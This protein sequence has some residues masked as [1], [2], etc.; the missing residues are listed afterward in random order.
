M[1]EIQLWIVV[2]RP[3]FQVVNGFLPRLPK[4]LLGNLVDG[5][6]NQARCLLNI[7]HITSTQLSFQCTQ[8]I[9]ETATLSRPQE[10][11]SFVNIPSSHGSFLSKTDIS[12]TKNLLFFFLRP[13]GFQ[14]PPL[15]LVDLQFSEDPT[16]CIQI[17]HFTV[18]P[19]CF[20]PKLL[21]KQFPASSSCDLFWLFV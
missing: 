13:W 12:R 2:G 9:Y 15:L 11:R 5:S 20:R 7:Q 16:L 17:I 18:S 14:Y 21:N 1:D 3:T 10:W 8:T 6:M 19:I 4:E